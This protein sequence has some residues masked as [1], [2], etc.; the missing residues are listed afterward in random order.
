MNIFSGD[1]NC[2]A[3]WRFENGALTTDSQGTNTLTATGS[4]TSDTGDYKEGTGCVDY[5]LSTPDYHSITDANL[6]AGFP[7]KSGDL[8]K[9]IS[10]CMWFKRESS[11]STS[12]LAAKYNDSNMDGFFLG[13]SAVQEI[14]LGIGYGTNVEYVVT[15]ARIS[16][17]SWYHVGITIDDSDRS[18]L[19]RAWDDGGSSIL[20]NKSGNFTNNITIGNSAF[21]IANYEG[22][23][24]YYDGKVD[25]VVVFDDILTVSEIDAIRNGRYPKPMSALINHYRQ[26][27]SM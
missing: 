20:E 26:T 2:K 15:T 3:L 10:L 23:T 1:S 18:Y 5:E 21:V 6:D 25:E 24:N 19:I 8:N 13:L 22:G 11:A 27:G 14:I 16:N 4:P 7:L 12:E 9:K 17:A